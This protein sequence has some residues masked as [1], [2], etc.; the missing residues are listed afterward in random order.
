VI[1]L[2]HSVVIR[3]PLAEV[4][5]HVADPRLDPAWNEAIVAAR[6]TSPEPIGSGTTFEYQTEFLGRRLTL[7][8]VI[9]DHQPGRRACVRTMAG[10]LRLAGCRVVEA[11]DDEHTRLTVTLETG[12]TGLL[13][14]AEGMAAE[15]A[16][17][18]LVASLG[19]LKAVL[20]ARSASAPLA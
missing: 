9:T 12:A 2:E 11:V 3:R 8:A 19:R 14:L 1:R 7:A 4:F 15:P 17:R 16:R 5:E 10:P 6:L 18:Q 13:R 20:E